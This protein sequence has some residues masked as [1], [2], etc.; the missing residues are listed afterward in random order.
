MAFSFILRSR[1]EI[2]GMVYF[3]HFHRECSERCNSMTYQ[4]P[5]TYHKVLHLQLMTQTQRISMK[6]YY[7]LNILLF[8][9]HKHSII[10]C[11]IRLTEAS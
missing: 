9:E 7:S 4:Q 5:M 3:H 10:Y 2:N 1:T 6:V 11:R 8:Y